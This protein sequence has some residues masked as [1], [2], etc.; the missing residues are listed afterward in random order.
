[1]SIPQTEEFR[2]KL[3]LNYKPKYNILNKHNFFI[4]HR[5]SCED[6]ISPWYYE[7][8][9]P[10]PLICGWCLK[11]IKE[12]QIKIYKEKCKVFNSVVPNCGHEAC[13]KLNSGGILGFKTW[14]MKKCISKKV[15]QTSAKS[16][17]VIKMS[18]ISKKKKPKRGKK[19][20]QNSSNAKKTV[21]K[22]KK[23][24]GKKKTRIFQ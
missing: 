16:V 8:K 10:D 13:V 11:N 7:I 4:D 17:N 12:T 14:K 18:L 3:L 6:N 9:N 20:K 1:M 21:K 22:Q 15:K 5:L 19:R 23:D 2:Q 24:N